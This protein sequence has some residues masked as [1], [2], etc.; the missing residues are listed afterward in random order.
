MCHYD[1]P[2]RPHRDL[3]HIICTTT[4]SSGLEKE[5]QNTFRPCPLCHRLIFPQPLCRVLVVKQAPT[6]P[7]Y[8]P[9][10]SLLRAKFPRF[11]P[12]APPEARDITAA[13]QSTAV[14]TRPLLL[15]FPLLLR[16]LQ[17]TV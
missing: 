12:Q 3:D 6:I 1:G 4:T 11:L 2:R 17:I 9:S 13:V 14:S 15:F 8:I 7:P 5:G 10:A 16:L